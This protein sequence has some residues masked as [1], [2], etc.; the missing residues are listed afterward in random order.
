MLR[1][2]AIDVKRGWYKDGKFVKK[3]I[4]ESNYA[5]AGSTKAKMSSKLQEVQETDQDR[6]LQAFLPA[7]IGSTVVLI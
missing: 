6:K 5:G 4:P 7:I 2:R 3:N 1:N